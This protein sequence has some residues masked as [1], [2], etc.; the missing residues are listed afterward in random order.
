MSQV[1][2]FSPHLFA[3]YSDD[4]ETTSSWPNASVLPTWAQNILSPTYSQSGNYSTNSFSQYIYENSYG[5]LH[6]IGDVFYVTLP[7]PESHYDSF[8]DASLER[9]HIESDAFDL[10]ANIPGINLGKYDNWKCYTDFDV[11]QEQDNNVDMCWFVMRNFHNQSIYI[12]QAELYSSKTINGITIQQGYP[13]YGGLGSGISLFNRIPDCIDFSTGITEHVSEY[14][15]DGYR[16][17]LFGS[18]AHELSHY[19]FGVN[20]FGQP[21]NSARLATNR[22]SSHLIPYNVNYS[23][24]VGVFMGYE[25]IR[26]GWITQSQIASISSNK[27]VTLADMETS[28]GPSDT[29]IVKI[30][31]P[32]T[33]PAQCIYIENRSW[34]S[35][36]ETRYSPLNYGK[37]LRPGLL[38][39]SIAYEDDYLSQS[40]V[41]EICEDGK[42]SWNLQ[43]NGG[44]GPI[45]DYWGTASYGDVIV[46]NSPD[47]VFG[48]DEREDIK[49]S[50]KMDA[51]YWSLFLPGA[52]T[53]GNK[54]I[55]YRGYNYID[56]THNVTDYNGHP[57]TTFARGEV[58]SPWSNGS[59]H[60]WDATN[61]RFAPSTIGIEI[62]GY[63]DQTSLYTLD[64]RTS[65]PE[66]LSPSRP[67]ALAGSKNSSLATSLSWYPNQEPD[68]INGNGSY[69]IYRAVSYNGS[70]PNYSLIAT[71]SSLQ[72]SYTDNNW[73][74]IFVP[75]NTI[76]YFRYK[77]SSLDNSSKESVLSDSVQLTY[78]YQEFLQGLASQQTSTMS[79]ATQCNSQRKLFSDPNTGRLH[80]VFGS[81][82]DVFARY[83]DNGGSTW[84]AAIRLS[85]GGG[86]NYDPSVTGRYNYFYWY[87]ATYVYVI[88]EKYNGSGFNIMYSYSTNNGASWTT[89]IVLANNNLGMASV[90]VILASRPGSYS[91][92]LRAAY[93]VGGGMMTA[94]T[95][96]TSPGPSD[97]SFYSV[98]GASANAAHQNMTYNNYGTY[99]I[100]YDDN[101]AIYSQN[102]SGSGWSTSRTNVSAGAYVVSGHSFPSVDLSSPGD[103]HIAWEGT[104]N[105]YRVVLENKNLSSYYN[106]INVSGANCYGASLSGNNGDKATVL[107]YDNSNRIWY[108]YV[109]GSSITGVSQIGTN[110]A[111][112]SVSIRNP[113]GGAEKAIWTGQTASP[114]YTV[115][116]AGQTFQKAE[117]AAPL[118]S[119]R[120]I[121]VTDTATQSAFAFGLGSIVLKG[122]NGNAYYV[123][124]SSFV[125]DETLLRSNPWGHLAT[126]SFVLPQDADSLQVDKIIASDS[127]SRFTE[128]ADVAIDVISSADSTKLLSLGSPSTGTLPGGGYKRITNSLSI[129]QFSKQ[130][131]G[132]P[133]FL[134]LSC[135]GVKVSKTARI[136]LVN[137]FQAS[138]A[139]QLA[140]QVSNPSVS[141]QNTSATG[142][143]LG[144]YPNP[145]NPSTTIQYRVDF[146][147]R[148]TLVV[149][150]IT[151][152]EVITLVNSDE[153]S[154]TYNVNF[155]ASKLPS[156]I[157]ISKLENGGKI[158]TQK[159]LL[160]K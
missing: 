10:L 103:E 56:E 70:N 128:N 37:L 104:Y 134:R 84:S 131:S 2:A 8:G 48:F 83:S 41:Q 130:V 38:A 98:P 49:V 82:G 22:S 123:N 74:G 144:N 76:S 69:K 64:I 146:P 4:N 57:H 109:L 133:I 30:A 11:R 132:K 52:P 125:A 33:S 137:V 7:Y 152:R 110:S 36:Y 28:A 124:L 62:T 26:L 60:Y 96:V 117:S 71:V 34:K 136:S 17:T 122:S 100:V 112:P 59:T 78:T 135:R 5:K 154:G 120:L 40:E 108:T 115:Q 129:T 55:W 85:D 24:P 150:D 148:V 126:E 111:Y 14:D 21:N 94:R 158:A 140:K 23:A 75:T 127:T 105:G 114:Y 3:R 72:S 138:G 35:A 67:Q 54:G 139:S 45:P 143:T 29:L 155:D 147:G 19:F 121:T 101:S 119:E 93:R 46:K 68:V 39:Y 16:Y 15:N 53:N 157:Y 89:P 42:W 43:T 153:A 18:M 27:V 88:W 32:G 95:T 118:N 61:G 97:W 116:M 156:G 90:P 106:L 31:I 151:G 1:P 86:Q 159:M 87:Y 79:S 91:F 51:T 25:K 50:T 80:E 141:G 81:G 20:H 13:G 66:N 58:I 142:P 113:Q 73:T 92:E 149:Y 47:P 99:I 65:N 44:N 6:I 9:S 160:L 77:T 63:N 145:F 102:S 12:G 107:F